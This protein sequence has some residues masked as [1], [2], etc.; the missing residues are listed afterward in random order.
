V[1]VTASLAVTDAE[2]TVEAALDALGEVAF[3]ILLR[4]SRLALRAAEV[5]ADEVVLPRVEW[6]VEVKVRLDVRAEVTG[7]VVVGTALGSSWGSSS[8][9]SR[10][11]LWYSFCLSCS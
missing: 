9:R 10:T 11:L 6:E 2:V 4:L 8:S 5:E 1:S 3:T 7:A